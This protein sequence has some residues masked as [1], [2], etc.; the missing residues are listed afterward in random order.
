MPTEDTLV[1][2]T[3]IEVR[4]AET[5][6]MGV[7]HHANYLVWFELARTDYCRRLGIRY[8]EIEDRG[9]LLMV[10]GASLKYRRPTRYGED[11]TVECTLNRCASRGLTFGYRVLVDGR[12]SAVGSTDHIWVDAASRRP[13]TVPDFAQPYFG[14]G[15]GAESNE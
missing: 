6:Q 1:A 3:Q 7:V 9:Y 12:P 2:N 8:T 11:V 15:S 14:P 5:D 10:V 4:Y 13:V